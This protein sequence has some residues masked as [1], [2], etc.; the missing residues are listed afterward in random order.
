MVAGASYFALIG[1]KKDEGGFNR[2]LRLPVAIV[3]AVFA[4]ILAQPLGSALQERITTSSDPGSLE[5]LSVRRI[6]SGRT[7]IHRVLT[8]S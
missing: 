3:A 2:L 5:V 8:Q 7:T 6:S 1:S 4:I